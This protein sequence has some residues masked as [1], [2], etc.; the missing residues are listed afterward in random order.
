MKIGESRR[1]FL[2]KIFLVAPGVVVGG[3]AGTSAAASS[4]GG[5]RVV[6]G[7]SNPAFSRATAFGGLVYASGVVGRKPGAKGTLSTVFSTQCRQAM[8]NLK[9]SVEAAGST[10]AQVLK[11]TCFLT[12]VADF[13]KMN[14]IFR[15][16]FPSDPPAR[17]TVVVKELVVPGA[18]L[19][20][21][22]VTCVE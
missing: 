6:G 4:G 16:F 21:D 20:I 14:A 7:S 22:C 9:T 17:S 18:K 11:C 10:M 2:G 3:V 19:E 13:P 15:S 12:D 1:V 5:R 8:E